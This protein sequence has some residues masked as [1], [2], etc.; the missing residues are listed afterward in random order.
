M[1]GGGVR[2]ATHKNASRNEKPG[3]LLGDFFLSRFVP[4]AFGGHFQIMS[5]FFK[6]TL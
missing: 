2:G 6:D 5:F 3:F 1:G 4:I